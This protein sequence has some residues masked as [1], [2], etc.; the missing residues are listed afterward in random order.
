M[1][2]KVYDRAIY[3]CEKQLDRKVYQRNNNVIPTA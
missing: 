3:T 1:A 2:R